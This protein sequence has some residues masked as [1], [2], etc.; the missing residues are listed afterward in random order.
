MEMHE[1]VKTFK[2]VKSNLERKSEISLSTQVWLFLTR[3]YRKSM[4]GVKGQ[5]TVSKGKKIHPREH[6]L[7]THWS[8]GHSKAPRLCESVDMPLEKTHLKGCHGQLG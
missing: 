4:G 3:E 1:A 8:V 2:H 7:N 5:K 6:N